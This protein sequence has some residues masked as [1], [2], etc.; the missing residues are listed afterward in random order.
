MK[1]KIHVEREARNRVFEASLR[2]MAAAHFD[3]SEQDDRSTS[4]PATS[5]TPESTAT[6]R[7]RMRHFS[8]CVKGS[9]L[10]LRRLRSL[11]VEIIE[12]LK[13]GEKREGCAA[14]RRQR[15]LL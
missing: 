8:G 4:S 2:A 3:Y 14:R 5:S 13:K 7:E 9:V 12:I 1:K 11:C 10:H 6:A 15:I